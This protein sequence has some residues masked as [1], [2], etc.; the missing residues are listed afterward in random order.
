MSDAHVYM[1][2]CYTFCG[3]LNLYYLKC[4]KK[5]VNQE[6]STVVFKVTCK[7]H[8]SVTSGRRFKDLP[9]STLKHLWLMALC[10][11]VTFYVVAV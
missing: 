5:N 2:P 4:L 8:V 11:H 1:Y 7:S 9:V 3:I 6:K 10:S